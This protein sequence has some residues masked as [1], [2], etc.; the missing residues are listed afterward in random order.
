MGNQVIIAVKH[1]KLLDTT[2]E[3]YKDVESMIYHPEARFPKFFDGRNAEE[4]FMTT[5]SDDVIASAYY[6]SH[7]NTSLILSSEM[8]AYLPSYMGD[9]PI[10][11]GGDE[12]IMRE[13]VKAI[14]QANTWQN[15]PGI[16]ARKKAVKDLRTNEKGDNVAIFG[17]LTDRMSEINS[18][19]ALEHLRQTIG[20]LPWLENGVPTTTWEHHCNFSGLKGTPFVGIGNIKA[21]QVALLHLHGNTF[22]AR[23]MPN[24]GI[25]HDRIAQL[26]AADR[27]KTRGQTNFYPALLEGL[28]Y[29]V[30]EQNRE[31][32]P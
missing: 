1:D 23:T 29:S 27:S 15:L 21:S 12:E 5:Y 10:L 9:D 20:E 31:P 6:D 7:G 3:R 19:T 4:I 11:N 2:T 14:K 24:Y 26:N 30:R 28:G 18:S 17:V 22:V 13:I 32:S 8:L 16:S 25:D